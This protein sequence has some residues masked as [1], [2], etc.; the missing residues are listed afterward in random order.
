MVQARLSE[1]SSIFS[2]YQS[3]LRHYLK[4]NHIYHVAKTLGFLSLFLLA[5]PLT[6]TVTCIALVIHIFVRK[7]T[8]INPHAKRILIAN[9][10]KTKALQL[11]RSFYAAGHYV[12]FTDEYAHSTN[13]YSRCVS[14]FYLSGDTTNEDEYIQSLIDIVRQEKID[15]FVPVS[16]SSS[17][18]LDAL[19]KEAL[20]P[21]NCQTIHGD[22]EQLKMLSDKYAFTEC[23]RSLGL[24]VPKGYKITDPQQVLD[25]DFAK[26][27]C[28]FILKRLQYDSR[29]RTNLVKLPCESRTAMVAYLNS[30]TIN[31]QDPWIMQE[32]ISG[33]EFCTHGTVKDGEL[34]LHACC[35]SSS[36]LLNYKHV[37]QKLNIL[38]WVE[39][40]CSRAH[41]TG[42]V[43]LDFI[44][45]SENGLV[46][47]IECNPRTHTAIATFYN[48]PLVAEAYIGTERLINGP[49][50][51][52]S[53]A[54]PVYWLYH[55]LWN[56]FRI[57]SLNDFLKLFKLFFYGKEAFFSID[58][59]LPF[60]LH[61]S[62]HMPRILIYHLQNM[63]PFNKIDCNL[64]F[65]F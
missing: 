17:E 30:L 5:F 37:D 56:L 22:I 61:Y 31:D 6:L 2:L 58:D 41:L 25:F 11:A 9:A 14:R 54:R 43:S 46:Y 50:Q 24:T 44:E 64:A 8:P 52:K 19:V 16:H 62:V 13:R 35:E 18:C 32:F 53:T 34:R 36:W 15:F 38:Q 29:T 59:P 28:Q 33:K 20:L 27:S 26:E 4:M 3:R 42:Q 45:S 48:H 12:V 47:A 23:A 40:F 21:Y 51:P 65:C 55:E 49:I 39:T 57:R 10:R 60:F 63:I 7:S 1:Q